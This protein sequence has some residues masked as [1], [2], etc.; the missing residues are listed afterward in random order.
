MRWVRCR[1]LFSTPGAKLRH[2]RVSARAV[3]TIRVP[4]MEKGEEVMCL[5]VVLRRILQ[6]VL[7][8]QPAPEEGHS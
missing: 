4:R 6:N 8:L 7:V 2:A 5:P 3:V 1:L